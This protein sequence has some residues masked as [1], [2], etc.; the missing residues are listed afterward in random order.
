MKRKLMTLSIVASTLILTLPVFAEN[1]IQNGSFENYSVNKDKGK[2]KLVEFERWTGAGEVWTNQLGKAA[3]DAEHKMELDVGREIN[4]LSQIVTTVQGTQYKLSLDAYARRTNS[5][6]FQILVDGEVL[7]TIR[8]DKK[9]SEYAVYFVGTGSEQ[10]IAFK[11]LEAQNNGLG[12]IID[13]VKLE[14]SQEMIVNGSFEKFSI[15]TDNGRSK[16]VTFDAW[17]G[18]GEVLNNRLG[19]RSTK[20]AYKIELDVGRELNTLSQSVQTENRV[21]YALSLDAYAR[22]AKSSDF[23]VWVDETKLESIRPTKEWDNYS[24]K[25]F[26]NGKAQKIQI[27]EV[28]SQNNTLGTVIDNVSLVPTGNYDNRPPMISGEAK[29]SVAKYEVF[30]FVPTVSDPDSDVLAFT[31]ENKPTWAEF[32]SSTGVLSGVASEVGQS[33]NIK[34]SVSDGKLTTSLEPFSVEVTEAVDIAQH[35][36]KATQPPKNGY[37][38]YASPDKMID[39]DASTNNHT[40]GT[41]TENWVQIELPSPTKISELMIQGRSSHAWRLGGAKVYLSN[42]PYSGTVNET[43][44]VSVLQGTSAKQSI[45]FDTPKSGTYLIIK[46]QEARPLHIATIEVYGQMPTAPKFTNSEYE[47]T[48]SKW[49][50]TIESIFNVKATDY[51]NDVLSYD[52]EGEV[53]FSI[54]DNGDI[55]VTSTLN[56]ERYTFDIVVS[57]RLNSTKESMTVNISNSTDV[58]ETFRSNDSRPE[59]SGF[60]PNIY[61][62]GDT[63]IVSIAGVEYEAS[64][65]DGRWSV[66]ADRIE[67]PIPV[68]MYNLTLTVNGE[69][70][71][72]A[73]YFEIYSSMLQTASHTLFMETITQRDVTVASYVETPLVKDEKVRASSVW[74][75]RE[76]GQ[77]ILENKSYREIKS[78]LGKY[79]DENGK[80][81]LVKLAFNQNLLPYSTNVLNNFEDADKIEIVPTAGHFDMELSFGKNDCDEHT[82]TN[83]TIYCTPTT[84]HDEVYSERSAQNTTDLSEQQV[85]SVAM[86][87]FHHLYNSLDGL[88][89]MKAWV[90]GRTYKTLDYTG[91][92]QSAEDYL[93]FEDDKLAYLYEKYFRVTMPNNAVR[94]A[95]MRYQYAAEGMGGGS[96]GTL[97]GTKSGGNFAS[98]WEG[99]LK[100]DNN[101]FITYDTIHHEAMHAIGFSH[102]S[103]MTY[104][105][106]YALRQVVDNFYNIG[107]NPVVDVPKYLFETKVLSENQIQLTLHKTAEALEDEVTF[108][109]LSGTAV[110][111]GDYTIEQ[112]EHDENNQVTLT[113]YSEDITRFFIRVYGADSDEL[114]SKMIIPSDTV[115]TLIATDD[116]ASKTYHALSHEHWEKGAK[117]LNVELKSNETVPMCKLWLGTDA[118]IAYKVDADKL[119]SDFRSEIDGATWLSSKNLIGRIDDWWKYFAYDYSDGGYTSTWKDYKKLVNDETLGILCVKPT[120]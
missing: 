22:R 14:A 6:D 79:K 16:L 72:Y 49:M 27:K 112:G 34:I 3:T 44:E 17:E 23:E 87:T 1:L 88:N 62:D 106:S 85:Y 2:R 69:A 115:Q 111:K 38:Y 91:D 78:L 89:A 24:F 20:G 67:S 109:I 43:E 76:S 50:N 10:V 52:I 94:Y 119:N 11:E 36:G 55:R 18:K 90:E 12:T 118:N 66:L 26:G 68:G 73:D 63:L 21:E 77:L 83:K 82:E 105:W 31:I 53:P 102:A 99:S 92:Y 117:A 108:E 110:M 19:K 45:I 46:G 33:Q 47:I 54:D 37:Y 28:E 40:Q 97:L 84:R 30:T 93:D 113:L 86:A 60:V 56:E 9:W 25:F 65:N 32:N 29:K 15:E 107:K 98:S 104:G 8:P 80:E 35:Y 75:T 100:Y 101:R 41:T 7:S 42:T 81:I 51:Q 4:E 13:N 57:D 116:N 71:V 74:L 58:E 70:I 39:G 114:M 95:S 64:V 103:G 120:K 61:S 96:R 5:S 59:L 48:T